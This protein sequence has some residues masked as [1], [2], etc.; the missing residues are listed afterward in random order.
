MLQ[1]RWRG[2]D[3]TVLY[4]YGHKGMFD[5]TVIGHSD[6]VRRCCTVAAS[7]A[8]VSAKL[9]F[10]HANTDVNPD[11]AQRELEMAAQLV[12]WADRPYGRSV[13]HQAFSV[14]VS[15]VIG[16]PQHLT[17]KSVHSVCFCHC[18]LRLSA[19]FWLALYACIDVSEPP[20]NCSALCVC[21]SLHCPSLICPRPNGFPRLSL[22]SC[23]R[24]YW[25]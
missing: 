18:N 13:S 15:R 21:P 5:V 14:L 22:T 25:D 2:S 1:V 3:E 10:A 24:D 11:D 8:R 12:K 20:H 17:G 9:W 19:N 7:T 16:N 23:A 4:R 6:I